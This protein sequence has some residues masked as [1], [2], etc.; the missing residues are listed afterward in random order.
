MRLDL[1]QKYAAP[2]PRYTSYPTAPQFSGGVASNTYE[3]WLSE[4]PSDAALSLYAHI[5]FCETLCWYCGCTTKAT[6]RYEPVATYVRSLISEMS[7]VTQHTKRTQVVQHMHWGGG[8]PNILDPGDIVRLAGA[9]AAYFNFADDIE[10]AV[11]VDPRTETREQTAAF[12]EAG[13]TRV[14]LG[15]Q[16][17]DERVQLAIN[18]IQSFERTAA[19]VEDFRAEGIRSVNIDLV[20]GLPRQT[21]ESAL[22]TI[23]LVLE[24]DPD[25]IAL[26][27]YAH[28]PSRI[29]HQRMINDG[30][31]PPPLLRFE[32]SEALA[33]RLAEGGYE[34]IGLDHFAKPSDPLCQ[35]AVNRNFQGYTHDGVE[36]LIGLGASAIGKLP[37]GYVQNISATPGYQRAIRERG[38]ATARG[39]C[40]TLEDRMRAFVIERLM[41]DFRFPAEQLVAQFGAQAAEIIRVAEELLSSNED[42]L[43]APEPGGV[44]KITDIGRPFVRTIAAQFD[45]YLG[46]TQA[47]YSLGI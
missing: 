43:L 36:T 20:Y 30:D 2:V 7:H 27:G 38:L 39:H 35:L 13:V 5:P 47:K 25:R 15:V 19:L 14:S 3:R 11:E 17:F 8:S 12:A 23:D 46:R 24:L 34:R 1:V 16:D 18:R 29:A 22:R 42:N 21:L 41:C 45:S 31:V 6:K 10:F 33:T 28:L 4:L 37:Q 44:F 32:Q 9:F 40:F 26:F